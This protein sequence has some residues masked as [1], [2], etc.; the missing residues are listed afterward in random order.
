[1]ELGPR[2]Q[3]ILAALVREYILTGEA[4][5]S[6]T[7]VRRHGIQQ[8]AATVRN[9]MADLEEQGLLRQPHMSAGRVP[10]DIGLRFFVDRLMQARQLSDAEEQDIRSRYQLS[11]PELQTLLREVSRLLSDISKQCALVLTP[12][13]ELSRLKRIEFVPLSQGRM[14]AVLVMGSG[15]VQNRLVEV[16]A[17]LSPE[18]LEAVHR[19]LNQLCEGRELHDVRRVVQEELDKEQ[20]RYDS[21]VARALALGVEALG[22]PSEAEVM[23]EGQSNLLDHPELTDPEELKALLRAVEEKRLVLRLLDETVGA[24]GVQVFIGA[25]TREAEMRSCSV[26]LKA[27]GGQRPLGTL[28]VI[29]PSNMDYP[30]VISIVDFAAEL[31]TDFLRES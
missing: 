25:E 23:I 7:L 11:N 26:V 3:E 29:G 27:Y 19:Y 31:L 15:V 10:T 28:G 12:R 17:P 24:E 21:L 1:M 13:R 20:N 4:V 8:S 18:E 5:G 6:R 30:R 2:A 14:I 22:G 9:V 16:T